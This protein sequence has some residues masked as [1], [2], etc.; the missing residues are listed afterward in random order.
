M[1]GFEVPS[2]IR[3][4]V[5]DTPVGQALGTCVVGQVQRASSV[6]TPLFSE[7]VQRRWR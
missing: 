5:S 4:R 3:S 7:A 1:N 6:L 2:E